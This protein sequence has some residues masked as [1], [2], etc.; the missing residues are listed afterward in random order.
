M[1]TKDKSVDKYWDSHLLA[2]AAQN[3]V[4]GS[5]T[6][7]GLWNAFSKKALAA[8]AIDF[9]EEEKKVDG[10]LQKAGLKK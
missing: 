1:N 7:R 9:I 10:I 4:K 2:Q 6:R 3:A 8:D 5:A